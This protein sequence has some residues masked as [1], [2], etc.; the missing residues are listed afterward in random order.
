MGYLA[1]EY[2]TV[3]RFTEKSDVY[4]FG[5][6]IFQILT[7]KTNVTQLR[8][9]PDSIKLEDTLDENLHGNF[10]KPEA[11]KLVGIAMICMSEMAN[12]RPTMEAVLQQL[13]ISC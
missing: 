8:L 3:G 10:S 1:P 11:A 6:V 4:S 13:S 7:G 2:T 5:V 9:G 12:Q